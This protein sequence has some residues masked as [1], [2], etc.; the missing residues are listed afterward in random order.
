MNQPSKT[1]NTPSNFE[2]LVILT[3][4]AASV[5]NP[6]RWITAYCLLSTHMSILTCA[7]GSSDR[8]FHQHSCWCER[9]AYH[10]GICGGAGDAPEDRGLDL[11]QPAAAAGEDGWLS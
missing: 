9:I 1:D 6:R 4:L 3:P 11:D 2:G 10:L 7:L 5:K 8:R